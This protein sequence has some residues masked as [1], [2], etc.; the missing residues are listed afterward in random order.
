[1]KR[2]ILTGAP[3]SGKTS[4]LHALRS[5]GFCVVEDAATDVIAREQMRGNREPHLQPGFIDAIVRLQRGNWK[6]RLAVTTSNGMTVRQCA[7]SR[8]PAIWAI[9]PLRLCERNWRE[10]SVS[11]FTRGRCSSS[12][13]WSSASKLRRE[14]SRLK[15]RSCSS[16]SMKQPTSRWATT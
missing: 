7:R 2:S 16:A 14:K 12:N 1:M 5:Q 11:G 13:I 15:N 10:L 6:R 3:C 9:L 8:F 4:I